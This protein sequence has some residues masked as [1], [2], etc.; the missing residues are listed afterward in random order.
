MKFR[1]NENISSAS[2]TMVTNILDYYVNFRT[3]S[4]PLKLVLFFSM[5]FLFKM[6][7]NGFSFTLKA[8][9]F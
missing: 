1:I 9:F 6:M 3:N 7:K 4:H 5:K 8:L 2:L